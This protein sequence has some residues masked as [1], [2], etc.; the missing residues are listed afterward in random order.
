M[1]VQLRFPLL[2][3]FASPP[4]D[5]P[6]PGT[7]DGATSMRDLS[8]AIDELIIENGQV[9]VVDDT[10]AASVRFESPAWT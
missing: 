2:A 5:A 3:R 8:F 4:S 6:A 10:G 1:T 9:T 7:V